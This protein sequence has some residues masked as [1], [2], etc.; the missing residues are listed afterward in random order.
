VVNHLPDE[1]AKALFSKGS[2][3]VVLKMGELGVFLATREVHGILIPAF[4]V[5]AIDTTA[6]GDAFNGGFATGLML[7]KSPAESARFAAAVAGISVTRRGAQP[8]MPSMAEVERFLQASTNGANPVEL[9]V[10]ASSE[11]SPDSRVEGSSV[12]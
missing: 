2:D 12:C 11:E 4:K 1:I 3:G 5:R 10:I 9:S 7:G 6:A 8:S